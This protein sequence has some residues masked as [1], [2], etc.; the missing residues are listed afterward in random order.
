VVLMNSSG[1]FNKHFPPN[2]TS[3]TKMPGNLRGAVHLQGSTKG[4]LRISV[5]NLV[6]TNRHFNKRLQIYNSKHWTTPL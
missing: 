4:G 2:L 3:T 6:S 1:A 5:L